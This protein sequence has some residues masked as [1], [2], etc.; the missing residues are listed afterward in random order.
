MNGVMVEVVPP[1]PGENE[2]VIRLPEKKARE[3]MSI[4][5]NDLVWGDIFHGVTAGDV[6]TAL[7]DAGLREA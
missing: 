6:Y 7:E 1:E 5:M 4:L 3:L 2:V